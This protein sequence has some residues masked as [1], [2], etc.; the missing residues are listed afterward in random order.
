M[1]AQVISN[2]VESRVSLRRIKSFL[3]LPELPGSPG[4][5]GLP[6][7]EIQVNDADFCWD[8]EN[9][10]NGQPHLDLK[11]INLT[12]KSGTLTCI[13]GPVGSGKSSVL[14]VI[15]GEIEAIPKFGA[16]GKKSKFDAAGNHIPEVAANGTVCY[17]PQIPFLV[18]AT[19]RENIL[20]GKPWDED[21]YNETILHCC[22][23]SDLDMLIAGDLTVIG[24]RGINL[25]GGQKARIAMARAIYSDSDIYLL[26]DPL[27]AVD[28]HVGH[29]LFNNA[30]KG[31]LEHGKTV[32][33]VTH[34][35][36]FVTHGDQLV[37]M[38]DGSIT[39]CG[40]PAA[41]RDQGVQVESLLE[42]FN[43]SLDND[44]SP[45][46][47]TSPK[48]SRSPGMSQSGEFSPSSSQKISKL[49]DS[50]NLSKSGES[51]PPVQNINA[52][53]SSL[54]APSPT[55]PEPGTMQPLKNETESSDQVAAN[56]SNGVAHKSQPLEDVSVDSL[57]KMSKQEAAQSKANVEQKEQRAVGHISAEVYKFYFG[58]KV[59]W[60]IVAVILILLH[61]GIDIFLK[62]LIANWSSNAKSQA[63]PTGPA[64][65][66]TNATTP[67][68]PIS[69]PI[70]TVDSASDASD[71]LL[72]GTI[73]AIGFYASNV[74][75]MLSEGADLVALPLTSLGM[76]TDAQSS[77]NVMEKSLSL[78]PTASPTNSSSPVPGS[79]SAPHSISA[80]TVKFL[81]MFIIGNLI[82]AVVQ[83]LKETMI[84]LVTC[85]TGRVV[86]MSM[87][88]RLL[89]A[90]M[91]FFDT[92]PKGRIA[93]R[94]SSDTDAMDNQ[95]GGIIT[96]VCDNLA[97]LLSSLVSIALSVHW[98][99]FGM[100]PMVT[101]YIH[102]YNRFIN[103][104]RE[105][106][107][108][109]GTTKAPLFSQFSET[110][111]GVY[112]LR[113]YGAQERF[114]RTL[115]HNL[116]SAQRVFFTGVTASRWLG[117][118]MDIL[119]SVLICCVATVSLFNRSV[120]P[121]LMGMALSYCLLN[122]ELLNGLIRGI[123]DVE[124]R[125][126]S[127]ERLEQYTKIDTERP[128]I[129]ENNRPSFS[130]PTRGD[131]D[132]SNVEMRY[133]DGLPL[134]LNGLSFRIKGGEKIGIVGRTGAGKSSLL[135]AIL[136]LSE[137]E[138]G[139]I[140]IDGVDI[141]KI[142]VTDL[143]SRLSIIPQ[144]PTIFDGNIRHNID[145]F[146]THTDDQIWEAL[147]RVHLFEV[148]SQLPGGI[149]SELADEGANFSLGQRQLMCVA[150]AILRK[151]KILLL[152]EASS[153]ID[154]ETDYLLQKTL[155]TEFADCTTITIAHRI[156][157]IMDSDRVMV[158]EAGKLAEFDSPSAL[159]RNPN[160]MFYSLHQQ[161]QTSSV[162]H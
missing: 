142:G 64:A 69:T 44:A 30:I 33:L 3:A 87:F 23:A 27:S 67:E 155:R 39:H 156:A 56:G 117:L 95:L 45:A 152:D 48:Q 66:S 118:R 97:Q 135:T 50:Q 115:Y 111:N 96:T 38:N 112:T 150:R 81:W 94:C 101:G 133:R 28:A 161:A 100:I 4:A 131:I 106:T 108:L 26:D 125:M 43:E 138:S 147:R 84:L 1:L 42:K 73:N 51:P 57:N 153:S 154:L 121:G 46:S 22:L 19:V 103:A 25:S 122:T 107:R 77:L 17:A 60:W 159:L 80:A 143:R 90:P 93:A 37:I 162:S 146:G 127:V 79:P 89:R 52:R 54:V 104:Y 149:D 83:M 49:R 12:C 7:G 116:D 21:R 14:N 76:A 10:E 24:E 124:A 18:H 92:T 65:P 58:Q 8:T 128:P 136:Q 82:L 41:L 5:H 86:Y 140:K 31:L 61:R 137:I 129:I 11:N 68:S 29:M 99:V 130:W 13:I 9:V 88:M 134:V 145:P 157:T 6:K 75:A 15:L 2:I 91:S 158:L 74:L 114:V 35:L 151:S 71:P 110:L 34:Q 36:Q 85:A 63:S 141:A 126:N 113:A 53:S 32:I 119:G 72:F 55:L 47:Q 59:S 123:S 102:F 62:V 105:L 16:E 109:T 139:R 98:F 40:T 78:E 160:S 120:D 20:F 144:D 148:V 132:F 70:S